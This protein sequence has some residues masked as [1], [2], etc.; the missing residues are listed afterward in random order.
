MVRS[1]VVVFLDGMRPTLSHTTATGSNSDDVGL[2]LPFDD[3]TMARIVDF[4]HH[5]FEKPFETI[6]Q[7]LQTLT[8]A[9]VVPAWYATFTDAMDLDEL[10]NT[11]AAA[12]FLHLDPLLDLL[13][14]KLGMLLKIDGVTAAEIRATFAEG[15][16]A[17]ANDTAAD[18][19]ETT[20]NE[21]TKNENAAIDGET[22]KEESEEK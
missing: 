19:E 20:T 5:Y 21:D 18:T 9:E 1:N 14:A 6:A 8:F 7:P 2:D 11:I 13:C 10:Y 22:A 4:S 12:N 17:A 3:A 16:T 15:E